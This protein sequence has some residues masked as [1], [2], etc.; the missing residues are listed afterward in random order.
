[1]FQASWLK[2]RTSD[3]LL[4]P[5]IMTSFGLVP[6]DPGKEDDDWHETYRDFVKNMY[7]TSYNDMARNR[8]VHV[9][10]DMPS[11]FGGHVPSVRH[12]VLFRNTAFDRAQ[13]ALRN[14]PNRDARPS[15]QDHIA[16]IPTTP[17]PR[18]ARKPPSFGVVP[19]DG[20]TTMLKPPWGVVT[21]RN[22]PL[23]HRCPPPTM[24]EGTSRL[25]TER[26]NRTSPGGFGGRTPR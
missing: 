22:F 1:M 14:D 15:F 12:D 25:N 18:G 10:S 19:H 8:E 17:L 2:H 13:E 20:T 3:P 11:G 6:N 9:K 5:L 23:S 7:R 26:L 21:T 4:R 16:G 24:A